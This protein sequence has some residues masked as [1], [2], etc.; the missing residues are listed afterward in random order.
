LSKEVPVKYAPYAVLAA[1]LVLPAATL[2]GCETTPKDESEKATLSSESSAAMDSFRNADPSLQALLDKSVGWVIFPDVG[3]AGFIA[4]GSYGRGE[5]YEG[6]AKIGYADITQATIGLQ[7]GAQTFS[8]LIVF[9]N[10]ESL[11]EFKRDEFAFAA[12]ASAIAIKSGAA[13]TAET[14][15]GTVVFVKAKGGLMAEASI[16]GQRF[17]FK[18]L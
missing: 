3:K 10:Q 16:G 11:D 4:G 17:R 14:T 1:A 2:P 7:I 5:V 9:M 13:G 18:P 8:E 15:G 6:G 12:N